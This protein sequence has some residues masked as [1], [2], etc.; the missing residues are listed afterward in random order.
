MRSAAV[1]WRSTSIF[2]AIGLFAVASVSP[3][4]A[5]RLFQRHDAPDV[6]ALDQPWRYRPSTV[7]D[8]VAAWGP[9]GRDLATVL[10]L[11]VDVALPLAYA[12]ALVGLILR[13]AP[14]ASSPVLR[15]LPA[16]PIGAAVADLTENAVIVWVANQPS[17]PPI[18]AGALWTLSWTKW[19]LLATAVGLGIFGAF[20]P[21]GVGNR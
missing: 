20:R 3:W 10:H 14:S 11:T 2:V 16:I 5:N 18:W 21:G 17:H 15:S 19:L 13:I 7:A 8:V 4:L 1:T 9:Y 6:W 12:A